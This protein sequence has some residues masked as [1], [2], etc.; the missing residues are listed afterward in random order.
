MIRYFIS[1]ISVLFR[2]KLEK[3]V[4]HLSIYVNR[5]ERLP[6]SF[7]SLINLEYLD[8]ARNR[9]DSLPESLA[10]LQNLK[11]LTM[12]YNKFK[13]IPEVIGNLSSLEHLNLE[14]SGLKTLP[15]FMVKLKTLRS[16]SVRK[17]L[18][19]SIPDVINWLPLRFLNL[20]G[21][22]KLGDKA[23]HY[24]DNSIMFRDLFTDYKPEKVRDDD[25]D[26]EDGLVIALLPK[27]HE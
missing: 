3:I 26:F 6:E 19:E 20:T 8:I 7:G 13:T 15:D 11:T 27:D 9:L 18:F 2:K 21:N 22:R 25:K 10:N 5:L 24:K 4:T 17:N 14:M 23:K 12:G 1:V 16:L